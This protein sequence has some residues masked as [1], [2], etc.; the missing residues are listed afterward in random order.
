MSKRRYVCFPYADSGLIIY[1]KLIFYCVVI[2][3][4]LTLRI[5]VGWWWAESSP[6][7]ATLDELFDAA[8]QYLQHCSHMLG[9]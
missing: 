3:H 2:R 4:Y 1:D 7:S 9:C 8:A 5:N 6:L